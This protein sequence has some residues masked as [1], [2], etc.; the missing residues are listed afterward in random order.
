MNNLFTYILYYTKW[1]WIPIYRDRRDNT[2]YIL[3]KDWFDIMEKYSYDQYWSAGQL[4]CREIYERTQHS[5]V[6]VFITEDDHEF[7]I[8]YWDGRHGGGYYDE[9]HKRL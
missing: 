3:E 6:L 9:H 4:L 5:E 8:Y 7:E 2:W 1:T